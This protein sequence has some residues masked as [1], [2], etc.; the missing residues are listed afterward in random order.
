MIRETIKKIDA[1]E[2]VTK[3][4][5]CDVCGKEGSR[6]S[7]IHP[8]FICGI[9]VCWACSNATDYLNTDCRDSYCGDYPTY[10]VC[11]KCWDGGKEFREKLIDL[12]KKYDT[13]FELIELEWARKFKRS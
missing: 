1:H 11:N 6:Y 3:T 13:D 12:T 4:R 10:H 9:D 8:C 5:V 7:A 2:E